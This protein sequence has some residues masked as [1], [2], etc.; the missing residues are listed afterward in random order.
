VQQGSGWSPKKTRSG[1]FPASAIA[2][3]AAAVARGSP[4]RADALTGRLARNS[5]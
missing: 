4:R 3:I 5:S 1:G 2:R